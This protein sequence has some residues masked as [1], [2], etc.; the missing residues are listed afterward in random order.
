MIYNDEGLPV[1]TNYVFKKIVSHL[2]KG[3][4]KVL[5]AG[6]GNN[7]MKKYAPKNM[8]FIGLDINNPSADVRADLEK[9]LPFKNEEFD[10]VILIH[11]IEHLKDP[12][13]ALKEF[14]R[15]LKKGGVI[16]ISTPSPWSAMAW[17]DPYH[18][19]PYTIGSLKSL[20]AD[21]K[22]ST[23]E[24]YYSNNTPLFGVLRLNKLQRFHLFCTHKLRFLSVLD[25][26]KGNS[27]M[28]LRK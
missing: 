16:F 9:K 22:L 25:F 18:I 2:P 26:F 23:A 7:W 28:I 20:A 3:K 27:E 10:A 24:M 1:Y 13:H 17:E 15:I 5:N 8:T 6:C 12:L 14:Q 21:A 4:L 11:V 19:R